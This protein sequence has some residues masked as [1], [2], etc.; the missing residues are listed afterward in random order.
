MREE[1]AKLNIIETLRKRGFGGAIS[2]LVESTDQEAGLKEAGVNTIFN[3][4]V[5][6]GSELA[7]RVV[8]SRLPI[9]P[10]KTQ[11]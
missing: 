7:E 2:A 4:L 11:S 6:A 1:E 9:K 8:M 5:Q 10:E 3:P